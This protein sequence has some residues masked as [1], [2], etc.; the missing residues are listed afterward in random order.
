[1]GE[2]CQGRRRAEGWKRARPCMNEATW[3]IGSALV[4]YCDLCAADYPI[5]DGKERILR[6]PFIVQP[7][8]FFGSESGMAW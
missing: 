5:F 1:M 8:I 2:I 3:L 6:V 7:D 4:P